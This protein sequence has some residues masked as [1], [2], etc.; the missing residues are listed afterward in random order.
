MNKTLLFAAILLI[1]AVYTACAQDSVK[2]SLN[3]IELNARYE[4]YPNGQDRT[5]VFLQYGRK[6]GPAEVFAKVWRYSLGKKVGHLFETDAYLKFK[7]QG[8]AYFDAAYSSSFLL[9][10]Y[11]F[12][13]ELFQNWK[14]FE[15]SLGLGMVKPPGF[16]SIPFVTGTIGYYFSDYFIY[17]RPTFSYIGDGVTRSIF[18]QAR[19]YFNKTD[20]IAL[21]G[22]RGADTGASRNINAIANTF[23]LNTYLVRMNGQLKKGPYKFGAGFDYG[24]F[25]IPSREDYLTFAGFDVFVNREF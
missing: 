11:R 21:S 6:I 25:F 12:R 2:A 9:P 14:R 10:N 15:Y 4:G 7:K 8:Y 16:N 13:A 5:Y 22:L 18:I 17:I 20:F 1:N 19:R 24:G 23:G 3:S